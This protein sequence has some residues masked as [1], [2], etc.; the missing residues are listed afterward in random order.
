MLPIAKQTVWSGFKKKEWKGNKLSAEW[1]KERL[2]NIWRVSWVC[3]EAEPPYPVSWKR[4]KSNFMSSSQCVK[5]DQ[6]LHNN[7]VSQ[8]SHKDGPRCSLVITTELHEALNK[9]LS[10]R[11]YRPAFLCG[12]TWVRRREHHSPRGILDN[13]LVR[14]EAQAPDFWQAM[15][16][17]YSVGFQ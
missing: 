17:L 10:H 8:N 16:G 1:D 5:T 9:V 11:L 4:Q 13:V 15:R 3:R 12:N 7:V 14:K 6:M 2:L